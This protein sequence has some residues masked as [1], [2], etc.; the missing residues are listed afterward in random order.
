MRKDMVGD[1]RLP[2]GGP[3]TDAV[4]VLGHEAILTIRCCKFTGHDAKSGA[5]ATHAGGSRVSTSL[6]VVPHG[7][8]VWHAGKRYA[9][10]GDIALAEK[11]R[12]PRRRRRLQ[13][14]V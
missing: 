4:T 10:S 13:P 7:E 3:A 12:A 5:S 6:L 1:G 9:G 14:Q 8:T 2:L 11:G